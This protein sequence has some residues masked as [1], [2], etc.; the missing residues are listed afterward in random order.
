MSGRNQ[1]AGSRLSRAAAAL[2]AGLAAAVCAAPAAA[3]SFK[4]NPVQINL[5][6]DR[7]ATSLTITNGDLAPVS[8]RVVTLAWHQAGGVDVYTPTDKVIVSPPIFTMAG[9]KSQL[10]RIGVKD[11]VAGSAYRVIFE[12]IP[13]QQPGA[14]QVQV[15][16]RLNLP[17][18]VLARGGGKA[19]V[20]WRAW[21]DPAGDLFVEGRNSGSAHGQVLELS[22]EQAGKR[23]LLSSE[24][25]VVLPG[26]AR[27]WKIGKRPGLVAGAPLQLAVRAP[28]GETQTRILLEQR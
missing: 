2:A 15:S 14:N 18:Y 1:Q 19:Q 16:L 8:L 23:Q 9:G 28:S 20:G 12:E 27:Y 21:R 17:L 7:G 26:S 3:A 13:R 6:A 24:M 22:A 10:V 4:V 25:G 11:R 5:P